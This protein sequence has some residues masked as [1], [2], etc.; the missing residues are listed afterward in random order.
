MAVAPFDVVASP[1]DVYIAP[2]GTTFPTCAQLLNPRTVPNNGSSTVAG[3]VTTSGLTAWYY[4]GYTEGGV[5]IQHTQT[6]NEITVDQTAYPVKAI[7]NALGVVVSFSIAELTAENFAH[8]LNEATISTGANDKNMPLDLG[9]AVNTVQMLVRF[10]S[11]LATGGT[12]NAVAQYQLST[13]YQ[14]G[15]P[16]VQF[17]KGDKAVLAVEFHVLAF[18][19]NTVLRLGTVTPA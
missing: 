13:V 8:A 15:T 16:Q 19:S 11:P 5:Q 3:Q 2:T 18:D 12:P 6:V 7:R 17:V 1:A 10:P 9:V 4:L 14:A